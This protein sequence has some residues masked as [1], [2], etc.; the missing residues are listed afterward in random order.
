MASISRSRRTNHHAKPRQL[1]SWGFR[2]VRRRVCPWCRAGARRARVVHARPACRAAPFVIYIL[3]NP[4]LWLSVSVR[5][6]TKFVI[7]RP[8]KFVIQNEGLHRMTK[9][10][11]IAFN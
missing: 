1:D 6:P 7:P 5:R 10:A 8:T 2:A 3:A 4:T 11:V 9:G